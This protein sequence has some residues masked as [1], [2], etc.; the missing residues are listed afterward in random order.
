MT[1][2]TECRKGTDKQPLVIVLFE[3][4][5]PEANAPMIEVVYRVHF[6]T[7]DNDILSDPKP[8]LRMLSATRTDTRLA[9]EL[10]QEEDDFCAARAAERALDFNPDA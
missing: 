9:V 3:R 8:V 10:T 7:S 4:E 6:L 1:Y 2:R 5:S